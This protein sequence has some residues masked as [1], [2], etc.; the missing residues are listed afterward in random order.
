MDDT[1]RNAINRA[2][3]RVP[4]GLYILT[5]QHEDRRCGMLTSWVQQVCLQPP[6]LSVA[7]AKGRMIMPLIS[8][9]R[10]FGLCQLAADDRRMMRKFAQSTDNSDD[11]FLGYELIH[12]VLPRVPIL[13]GSLAYFECLMTCHMDVDGDH[14]LFV[15][16]VKAGAVEDD[17]RKP[18]VHFRK[19][20]FDY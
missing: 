15:G 11:P 18:W 20:G 10:Q 14:D 12:G 17:K 2:L 1:T 9:S 16:E 5:A 3:S 8:E 7:V 13:A 19:D 4:S 6:M